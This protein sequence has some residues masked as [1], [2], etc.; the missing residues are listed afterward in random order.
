MD[1]IDC[2]EVIHPTDLENMRL[3][4]HSIETGEPFHLEHRIRRGWKVSLAPQP[5]TGDAR[6]QR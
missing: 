1:D 2:I 5:R 4:R 6:R 3:W